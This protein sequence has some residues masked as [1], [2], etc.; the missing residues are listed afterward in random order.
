MSLYQVENQWGGSSA[1]WHQGGK[2][3][4]GGRAEQAVAEIN[5][6]SHDGGETLTGTMTYQNEGPIGFRATRRGANNYDVENQWGGSSAPWHPGGQWIIGYRT[7][8]NVVGLN[9]RST[10]TG[11]TFT[12]TMTY[13][14]EGPIGFKASLSAGDAYTVENQWGGSDAPWHAGGKWALGARLDQKVVAMNLSSDDGGK[15][16]TGTMT[17]A[18]EG[19]IGFRG[20]LTSSNNYQVD[21]QWGGAN[22]PWHPGGL[23]VIGYRT[24][25]NVVALNISSSDDGRS[26]TGEMTYN[27]EGPI[28]FKGALSL[29]EET[30]EAKAVA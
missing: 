16:L 24:G 29:S 7:G 11:N 10:D 17:Y 9:I 8:Q 15:T 1:P 3:I 30:T 21:N 4:L 25:Q 23:W 27:G 5:I 26:F 14:G 2:W 20:R 28:A 18:D 13:A 6:E 22:A 12:G 19:P